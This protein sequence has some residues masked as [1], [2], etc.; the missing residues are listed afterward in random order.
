MSQFR[1]WATNQ[2]ILIPKKNLDLK[3]DPKCMRQKLFG[4]ALEDGGF[5]HIWPQPPKSGKNS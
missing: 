2:A 1:A 3:I 5:C 4:M